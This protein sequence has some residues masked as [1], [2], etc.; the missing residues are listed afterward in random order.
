MSRSIY[1]CI[2]VRGFSL[3]QSAGQPPDAWRSV[4]KNWVRPDCGLRDIFSSA[5]CGCRYVPH[6]NL[7]SPWRYTSIAD[8]NVWDLPAPAVKTTDLY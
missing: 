5:L 7:S 8:I 4:S 2:F 3:L 6:Y 1:V